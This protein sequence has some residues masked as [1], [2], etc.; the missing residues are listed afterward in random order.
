MLL[1]RRV[2]STHRGDDFRPP[3]TS[4]VRRWRETSRHRGPEVVTREPKSSPEGPGTSGHVTHCASVLINA[5]RWR[6]RPARWRVVP[7][8]DGFGRLV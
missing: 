1:R 3:V 2:E 7:T 5:P 8:G 4:C 6:P